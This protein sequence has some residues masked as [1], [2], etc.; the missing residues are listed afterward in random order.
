MG[1]KPPVTERD[2][3]RQPLREQINLKHPLVRLTDLINWERLDALMRESFVSH[4]G[5]PATSPRLI[6]GLLYLQHAF[7]LSDEEVVWQWVE[8]PYWQVFTGETY[9]QTEPPIDP[10]SLTR[11]RK[12]LGEAGVEELL[13]ETIDAARRAGVIKA[14]SVKRVI[15]DT[16][17]MEKA[18]AHPTDSRLLERCREH[19]VKA[20]A[21][22]GLKL[23]QNYNREAPR[24]A[25]QIGRYAHA[26]QFKRMRKALR[27]LRSRVGRVMR[28][29]ER[30]AG[31][32]AGSGH[33]A[34]LDLVARTKRILSQ[35]PKDKN[36][37]YALHAPEVEC[38][39][40]GKA[41]TPY[42]FGVKVSITTT[43]KEGLVVGMRSMPGNP[44][45]GHTPAEALEQ[46][47]ILS[48]TKPEVVIVDRGYKGVAIDGVKIYHPGL[49]RGITRTLRAMI[50]RRSAIEPAIGHMK[51]D[52]KLDRNWLKGALGDAMH[53]VLCG[54]GYN[55]RMILRKLRLLCAFVLAALINR[56]IA[57]D[58]MV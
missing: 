27:T 55:L 14:S 35:K 2:F 20:A 9:L 6:A 13:A 19:L 41:R 54:A 36:K 53:A 33:A 58:V 12:R 17:V 22:H 16:T 29:V 43:H 4:K 39:A 1:P 45:D 34:L 32:V 52:G 49:R 40:K 46:A 8:N 11:W 57:A 30:Q 56:R 50:R 51:M 47:E 21:R 44:Y 31:Q 5:R 42:E 48:D 24:L 37:L 15:V 10:S 3:F 18:I 28:D 26:K 38:L 23:R 7:D 25:L